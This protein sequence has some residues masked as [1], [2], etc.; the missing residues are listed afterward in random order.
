MMFI[1]PAPLA[2]G[3]QIR[4]E[5]SAGAALC[6]IVIYWLTTTWGVMLASTSASVSLALA[7][8]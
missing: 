2:Q 3:Q 1:I 5:R 7:M 4:H 6:Q 8:S